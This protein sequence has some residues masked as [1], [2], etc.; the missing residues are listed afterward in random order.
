MKIWVLVADGGVARIFEQKTIHDSLMPIQVLTHDHD[1]TQ[2]HDVD[3]P[4]RCFQSMGPSHHA[5][6]KTNDWH[7]RQ[8]EVFAHELVNIFIHHHKDHLFKKAYFICP[9]SMMGYIRKPLTKYIQKLLPAEKPEIKEY[10][11]DLI[12]ASLEDIQEFVH[13]NTLAA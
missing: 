12:H 3:K 5:Y 7:H 8:K 6:T 1:L 10:V 9:A 2:K 4:G 11:K 13:N